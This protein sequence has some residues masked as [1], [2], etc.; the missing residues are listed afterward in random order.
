[1]IYKKTGAVESRKSPPQMHLSE[2]Q[3]ESSDSDKQ[4]DEP[5]SVSED[6]EMME[7]GESVMQQTK[8]RRLI[9]QW[10]QPSRGV[11]GDLGHFLVS[12]LL[13]QTY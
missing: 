10:Q 6:E 13:L 8:K 3:Q 11:S 4:G 5:A 7:V 9:K 1:M 2:V 12:V